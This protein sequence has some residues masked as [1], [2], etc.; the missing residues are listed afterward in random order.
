MSGVVGAVGGLAGGVVDAVTG[1]GSSES[2]KESNSSTMSGQRTLGPASAQGTAAGNYSA[3]QFS[4][5]GSQLQ[6]LFGQS[7]DN[8][9]QVNNLFRDALI[10]FSTG[11]LQ[12][13]ADQIQQSTQF[14]D[15]T[16][17]APASQQ[18]GKFVNQAAETQ[19]NRA[20]ASGRS[21][22]DTAYQR[23]FAATTS[24]AANSLAA[25]RGNLIAQ[26]AQ[27]L[28]V[29]QPMQQLNSLLQGA[30][31]FN[32]PLQQSIANR[33]NLLN[34]STSQQNTDLQRQYYSGGYSQN[35]NG[36]SNSET[37]KQASLGD[38]I[39]SLAGSAGKVGGLISP[40]FS[41][42]PTLGAGYS[43]TTG[44]YQIGGGGGGRQTQF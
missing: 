39:G 26:Q 23:E 24:D 20:A 42:V 17:T 11:N 22:Q 44:N 35:Q 5:L 36:T 12:P 29:N 8:A 33:L 25:Q 16:F 6:D 13:T 15:Q 10:K 30:Q 34:A 28:A 32:T 7:S 4:Q 21:S 1:G 27:N 38:T 40:L 3:G 37:Q 2:K 18:F 43:P 9:A 14:V 19:A 41:P 31:Y